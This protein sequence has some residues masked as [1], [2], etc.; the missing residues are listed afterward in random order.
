MLGV[1]SEISREAE[2]KIATIKIL[3]YTSVLSKVFDY[4]II[5]LANKYIYNM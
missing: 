2:K 1:K 4:F 5:A 3:L